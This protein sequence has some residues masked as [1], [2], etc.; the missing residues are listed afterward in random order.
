MEIPWNQL[1]DAALKG[2]IEEFVTR[3]GTEYGAEE[4]SIT[5]K[6]EQ[7]LRQLQSGEAKIT[8]DEALQTCSVVPSAGGS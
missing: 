1:S 7:V 5:E 3:E 4:I 2:V 8:W 6:C